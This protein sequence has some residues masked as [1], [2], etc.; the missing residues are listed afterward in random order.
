MQAFL[1]EMDRYSLADVASASPA[2]LTLPLWQE[3]T[4]P[5][6]VLQPSLEVTPDTAE[7]L[8]AEVPAKPARR[9]TKA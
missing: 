5:S 1:E 3:V 9:V 2:L 4:W 8:F 6:R 7:T